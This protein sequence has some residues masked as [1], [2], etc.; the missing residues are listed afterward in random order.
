VETLQPPYSLV[1]RGAEKEILPFSEREGIGVI[2]YSP[3]GSGLPTGGIT[4]E[5]LATMTDDDLTPM[6]R[7]EACRPEIWWTAPCP[8]SYMR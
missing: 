5:R 8:S 4:R 2:V 6:W 3:M 1:D 7:S